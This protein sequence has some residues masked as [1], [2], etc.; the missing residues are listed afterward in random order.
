M[1]IVELI[2]RVSAGHKELEDELTS[3]V[4][5]DLGLLH[6]KRDMYFINK[7]LLPMIR[8]EQTVPICI[9]EKSKSDAWAVKMDSLSIGGGQSDKQTK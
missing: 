2:V 3:T 7:V 8:N 5:K 6:S 4:I 9:M 1:L